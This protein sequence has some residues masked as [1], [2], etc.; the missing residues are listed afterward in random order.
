MKTMNLKG[1][2][3][4]VAIAQ[5]GNF[6]AAAAALGCSKAFLS[7][8]IQ[9]LETQNRAQL[10]IRTTRNVQLT[11]IGESFVA[12]CKPALLAIAN[13]QE[14][15]Q[16]EQQSLSGKIRLACVGGIFGEQFIAPLVNQFLQLHPQVKLELDFSS[17]VVDLVEGHYDMAIRFGE[18]SDSSLIA[19]ELIDYRPVLL[20]SPDFIEK[21]G[22]PKQPH[23]LNDFRLITGSVRQWAFSKGGEHYQ[24]TPQAS[25][26]CGNGQVMLQGCLQGL[27]IAHLPSIY[28]EEQ[29]ASKALIE[30]LPQWSTVY[31][32]VHIL[33]PPSRYRLKRVQ[34]LVEFLLTQMEQQKSKPQDQA[35]PS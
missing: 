7:K 10:L 14:Q 27:G 30:L 20:A 19:R 9:L 13:A 35:N 24:H 29:L 1:I 21:Y 15:L 28:V 8:Q 4:L 17:S 31:R 25:L 32:P 34:V 12:Q 2:Q 26:K 11:Q 16:D 33:Y 22:S 23:D 18:L 6:T 5:Y 3:A